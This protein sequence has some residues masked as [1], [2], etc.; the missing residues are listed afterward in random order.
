MTMERYT[1]DESGKYKVN[2]IIEKGLKMR[3]GGVDIFK[4]V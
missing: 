1:K 3:N 2:K 4:M